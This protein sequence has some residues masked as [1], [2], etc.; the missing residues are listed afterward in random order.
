MTAIVSLVPSVTQTLAALGGAGALVGVTDYCVDGAPPPAR[1]VGGTKNP[2][3]DDVVALRPDVVVANAEENRA[4]D[5]DALRAAGLD[6]MVT[7]P[8]T[9]GDVED[10]LTQLAALIGRDPAPFVAELRAAAA[11]AERA[12]P[13]TP[14]AHLT[15]VWRKPWMGLGPDTY[16]DDLLWRCGFANVLAGFDERYPR[17]DPALVL[18]P[19]VVLLPSEPYAFGE[20]DLPAVREL[21]GTASAHFVDGQLLTWHGTRTAAALRR[22]SALAAAL[23]E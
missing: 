20:A 3:L 19:Q 16:A 4:A 2:R 14:V 21:T 6:V 5:L 18:A 13:R 9:V 11:A 17:L 23:A 7:F 1:R 12:R 8:R 15:L 22:F 10:L